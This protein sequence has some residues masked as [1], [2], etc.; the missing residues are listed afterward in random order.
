RDGRA[1]RPPAPAELPPRRSAAGQGGLPL[2]G[3]HQGARGDARPRHH[4]PRERSLGD[5]G[6]PAGPPAQPQHAHRGR[7]RT[8]QG[9]AAPYAGR[10]RSEGSVAA[11]TRNERI[12]LL[13]AAVGLAATAVGAVVEGSTTF[14]A[15]YLIGV[16]LW[17][18][19]SFGAL[20]LQ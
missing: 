2:R 9:G 12:A 8:A 17:T 6:L 4:D 20:G 1:A 7:A 3:G 15:A 5:R 10:R 14:F 16:L 11:M 13:V 18:Q 19:I